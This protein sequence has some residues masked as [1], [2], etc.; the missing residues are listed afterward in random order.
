MK[1]SGP[2][3]S[4]TVSAP[5]NGSMVTPTLAT[6]NKDTLMALER[7]L[8]ELVTDMKE[9]MTKESEMEKE[10]ISMPTDPPMLDRGSTTSNM[11]SVRESI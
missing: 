3:T 11:D 1:A 5:R 7:I 6:G 2:G 8:G 10:H 4:P 9:T